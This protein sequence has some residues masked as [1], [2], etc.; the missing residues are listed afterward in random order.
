MFATTPQRVL[1][2]G[3]ED[4]ELRPDIEANKSFLPPDEDHN[5]Q[6]QV[7][8]PVSTQEKELDQAYLK[9]LLKQV[10]ANRRISKFQEM[11]TYA[12]LKEAMTW[13][14]DAATLD[15]SFSFEDLTLLMTLF[16][17]FADDIKILCSPVVYGE[18]FLLFVIFVAF[19]MLP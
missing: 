1:P 7:E 8:E 10:A 4:I 18:L 19:F 14:L 16:V 2:I 5:H 12:Y 6:P 9:F 13:F 17:L 11:F 15:L 3:D